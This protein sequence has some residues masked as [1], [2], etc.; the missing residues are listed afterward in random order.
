MDFLDLLEAVVRETKPDF[1]KFHKPQ[2]LSVELSE[3][4]TGLDSLDMSLVMIVVGEIYQVPVD[5]LDRAGDMRTVSDMKEFME[6]NGN[7]IPETLAE[8]K[9]YI[10]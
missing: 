3:D 5:V 1:S 4:V 8:A 6:A 9:G 7:R 2:S 10:E